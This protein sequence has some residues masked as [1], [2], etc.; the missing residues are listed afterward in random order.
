MA[1]INPSKTAAWVRNGV[2]LVAMTLLI[3]CGYN[4]CGPQIETS[5]PSIAVQPP[6]P[7]PPL[8]V[9]P[10]PEPAPV[11]AAAPPAPAAATPRVVAAAPPAPETAP[12]PGGPV[13]VA[14]AAPI[15]AAAAPPPPVAPPAVGAPPPPAEVAPASLP[16]MPTPSPAYLPIGP[17]TAQFPQPVD[18]VGSGPLALNFQPRP[19]LP[20]TDN[21]LNVIQPCEAAASCAFN[22]P[23]SGPLGFTIV[24]GSWPPV[25]TTP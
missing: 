5:P 15:A 19:G 10:P 21:S 9:A 7:E 17:A 22:V 25:P 18:D 20:Q 3:V 4:V 16:P 12:P 24:G 6:S 8:P 23:G 1:E 11:V 14:A 13:A 2:V